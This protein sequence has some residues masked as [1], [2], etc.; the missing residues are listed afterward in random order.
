[1]ADGNPN[2]YYFLDVKDNTYRMR[3]KPASLPD[4]F[5]ARIT[6]RGG[7]GNH[8]LSNG[9]RVWIPSGPSGS[10]GISPAPRFSTGDWSDE[11]APLVEANVFDG[12][13]R[14]RVEVRFDRGRFVRMDYN[15]PS[16]GLTD[17][18]PTGNLDTYIQALREQLTG[19]ER[20]V[21]P[22]P[23]SHIWTAPVPQE[24]GP[25]AHT[26]TIRSTDPYGRRTQTSQQFDVIAP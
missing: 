3:F 11:Q 25:G 14:H 21:S 5:Q 6:F 13:E 15:P 22:E 7:E 20:P 16:F 17:G 1:M 19:A 9:E 24:L 23:S 10:D 12:G 26:V 8:T 4:D 2:G 18:D